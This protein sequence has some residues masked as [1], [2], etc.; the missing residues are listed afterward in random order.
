M[1]QLQKEIERVLFSP[2]LTD[3]LNGLKVVKKRYDFEKLIPKNEY[4]SFVL[5]MIQ[6]MVGFI[7][8]YQDYFISPPFYIK[9]KSHDKR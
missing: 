4:E 1:R 8:A 5:Q 2:I 7:K 3:Y 6:W 9:C